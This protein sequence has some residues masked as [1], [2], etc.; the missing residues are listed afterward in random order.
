VESNISA[1][2]PAPAPVPAPTTARLKQRVSA[3]VAAF[4]FS[5]AEKRAL[6]E[7]GFAL[8][9]LGEA[10]GSRGDL[11]D[12]LSASLHA[13]GQCREKCDQITAAVAHSLEED[14]ADYGEVPSLVRPLVILRGFADRGVLRA[15]LYR[16][17]KDLSAAC[18]RLGGHALED[19]SLSLP[20][21]ELARAARAAA[22]RACEDRER[23]LA[24]YGGV[25]LPP[26]VAKGAKEASHLT[27][28]IVRDVRGALIPKLP[29]VSGMWVGWWVTNT[30]TDSSFSAT[31]HSLGIGDG[32]RYAVTTDQ[33]EL[34]HRWLPI[35]AAAVCSY[36]G[37]R[38]GALIRARYQPQPDAAAQK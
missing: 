6:R 1:P 27:K 2:A 17:R 25:A 33:Y 13:V 5:R 35:V 21:A 32:P 19:A 14:R 16:A 28:T 20:S 36:L 4:R 30:F 26:V 11:A 7:H 18:E 10:L 12:N 3:G 38:L 8:R 15:R 37:S 23:V 34:M 31:L 24:P 29:A 22:L 9:Q